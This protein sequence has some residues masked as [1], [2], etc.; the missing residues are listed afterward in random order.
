MGQQHPRRVHIDQ[1]FPGDVALCPVAGSACQVFARHARI[2][3]F[4]ADESLVYFVRGFGASQEL[5]VA[6]VAGGPESKVMTMLPLFPLGPFFDLTASSEIL[7]VRFD[8]EP[9]EIWLAELDK[10]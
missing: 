9:S 6:P 3:R 8:Q 4:S 10:L 5:Y 2:P 1:R 7:W